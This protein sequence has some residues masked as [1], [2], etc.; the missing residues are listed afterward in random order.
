[1]DY[2]IHGNAEP[3]ISPPLSHPDFGVRQSQSHAFPIG[4]VKPA[5]SEL[6]I[7]ASY[8]VPSVTCKTVFF[9]IFGNFEVLG[10]LLSRRNEALLI[11]GLG[12][13]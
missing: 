5:T 4:L 3:S 8:V 2:P 13:F 10:R 7:A 9:G 1:M 6:S 11:Y 12:D